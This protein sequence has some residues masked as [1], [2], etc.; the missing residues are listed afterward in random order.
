MEFEPQHTPSIPPCN[1]RI[2][3]RRQMQTHGGARSN[4]FGFETGIY[5][6]TSDKNTIISHSILVK[7][8][9]RHQMRSRI[10]CQ[11]HNVTESPLIMNNCLLLLLLQ[12]IHQRNTFSTTEDAAT[13]IAT[14]SILL[15][16]F[17]YISSPARPALIFHC[18]HCFERLS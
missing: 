13:N 3:C 5:V 10:V 6:E 8:A 12:I 15:R 14:T 1:L 7:R 2:S 9:Q 18:Q 11:V 17:L 4:F 16:I